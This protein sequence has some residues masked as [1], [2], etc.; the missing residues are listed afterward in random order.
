MKSR[1]ITAGLIVT[2]SIFVVSVMVS[3][4]DRFTLA[5][6]DGIAFSEFKGYDA[7]Q[8]ISPSQVDGAIKAIVGN[9]VM[10]KAVSQGI[11]V[12]GQPVPDGA[13]MAK[14]EWSSKNNPDLPGAAKV[15][16][17]LRN[18]GFMVKDA[19]RFPETDGWGYAQFNY[20][21]VSGTFKPLGSSPGFAKAACHQ[22][23]MQFAK[24][25]DF[26]FSRYAPR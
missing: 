5:S 13:V 7:W 20:D 1:H 25:R 4:Q 17:T 6:P 10:I 22:C 2:V 24:Q 11:P 16:D 8:V 12:N 15:P 23:H 26:V 14:I 18:V 3:G 19:K 21:A 9:P